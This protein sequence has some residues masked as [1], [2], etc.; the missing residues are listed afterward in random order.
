MNLLLWG[1]GRGMEVSRRLHWTLR[2][3]RMR[4]WSKE[5]KQSLRRVWPYRQ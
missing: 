1:K 5:E 2:T 4:C 3:I